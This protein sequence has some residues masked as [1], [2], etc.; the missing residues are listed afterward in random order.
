VQSRLSGATR[1]ATA[2]FVILMTL[3]VAAPAYAR[4][5]RTTRS[6]APPPPPPP[7]K[8]WILVD[9]D[10]G[11]VID[12]GN[13]HAAL[14]PA[15]LTK[16]ITALAAY[17]NVAADDS[18]PVSQRAAD[19]PAHKISMHAGEEWT[20]TDTFHALLLSSA[21]DAAVALAE[22]AGGTVEQFQTMFEATASSL[23]MADQ[24]VLKDPAGLDGPD[25][26]E[27]GNLVSARDLAIAGRALLNVPELANIVSDPV[28]EFVGP[29]GV[30]HKIGNHN[31]LLTTY[32]GAIGMK[33]GYTRR[34]GQCLI[35]A[36]RRDG[37]TML[38][39]VLNAPDVL[40]QSAALLDK[41]FA[42]PV[43]SE[44]ITDQLP[45]VHIVMHQP[46][47]ATGNGLPAGGAPHILRAAS[48]THHHKGN[49]SL[50]TWI[51]DIVIGLA[52]LVAAL[53]VRAK[54]RIRARRQARQRQLARDRNP[55]RYNAEDSDLV[56]IE[57]ASRR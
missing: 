19:A 16:V 57:S 31:H 55:P 3:G 47:A 2:L 35:A 8:A 54:R 51:A 46:V 6:T 42:T 29:D 22:R 41:G 36:A 49:S 15:S 20:Y 17:E 43:A 26:V 23:G 32:Q 56:L 48:T 38:S 25:G 13:D 40:H 12:A 10:T 44:S 39:V 45:S 14:P 11:R 4:T 18:I 1:L 30:H 27:G 24:P 50:L 33:T 34:A 28:Y 7:P 9:V 37:R 52:A 5:T 53:R 21:N